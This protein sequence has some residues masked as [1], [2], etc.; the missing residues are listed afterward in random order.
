MPPL[1]E[2]AMRYSFT[3][4]V[5]GLSSDPDQYEDALYKA[6]C[7]DALVAVIDGAIFLDFDREAPSFEEAVRAATL[8]IEKAGGRVA[9]VKPIIE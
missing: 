7:D 5:S 1:E 4:R 8:N 6:G 3:V 9:E 2:R